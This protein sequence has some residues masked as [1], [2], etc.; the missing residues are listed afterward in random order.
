MTGSGE[1]PD[2]TA[3]IGGEGAAGPV[4]R[5]GLAPADF[6]GEADGRRRAART[7][8]QAVA[9]A[10]PRRVPRTVAGLARACHPGPAAAVTIL[11]AALV[12]V[13]GWGPAG[14]AL[15]ALAVLTGQL[16]V[17]WCNDAADAAVDAAAG[18]TAKPIV[19]GLVSARTV[20]VAAFS[21]LAACV[22]LSLACGVVAG[23]THLSAVAAA[24]VYNLWLKGTAASWA[25]YAAGFGAVPVFVAAGTPGHALPAWWAVLAAALL[26]CAAHLANVLPDIETDVATGVRGWPQRLGSARVRVLLPLPLL[27]ASALLVVAPPG[28][29]GPVRWL[30]LAG[31]AGCAAAGLLLGRRVPVAPFAAAIGAAGIDVLLLAVT[32]GVVTAG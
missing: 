5:A 31:V 32:P 29:A 27:A 26:G 9:Q 8:A 24:W 22:P 20:R 10:V 21:A 13:A 25:P 11:V 23:V 30:A 18:R 3:A 16:S 28:P 6:T 15:T 19:A 12:A 4:R 2:E 1:L 14:T 17:G 7:V